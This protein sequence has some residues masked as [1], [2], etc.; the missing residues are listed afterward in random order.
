M[1]EQ[2]IRA[3]YQRMAAS[4]QPPSCV[5][6]PA[7]RRSG[8]ARLRWRW[9][10]IAGTPLLTAAAV[11]AIALTGAIPAGLL[12]KRGSTPPVSP[13]QRAPRYFNPL[14]P[15]VSFGW[16]PADASVR[17]TGIYGLTS[18]MV[19][20]PEPAPQTHI[21]LAVYTA[22]RC[23]VTRH[24]LGCSF[25]PGERVSSVPLGHR[26]GY[27]DGQPAYWLQTAAAAITTTT[28]TTTLPN[29]P[30]TLHWQYARGGW[31]TLVAP[32]LPQALRIARHVR[33]GSAAST[34]VRFP[35]QLTGVPT[36]WQINSVA[37]RWFDGVQYPSDFVVTAGPVYGMPVEVYPAHTP[38]FSVYPGKKNACAR[39]MQ[40]PTSAV[41]NGYR[42]TLATDKNWIWP[43]QDLCAGDVSGMSLWIGI[44]VWPTLSA[45]DLFGRHMRLLGSDPA[46]W[47]TQPIG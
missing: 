42:V 9:A 15:Y 40:H 18:E 37:T 28:S 23:A 8:R 45:A 34:P 4:D 44:G 17:P 41:I 32:S 22:G 25:A 31:A 19:T 12:G 35:F 3:V 2:E 46:N 30:P 36:D 38:S 13:P 29:L 10:G 24:A 39:L 11:L 20:E 26:V 5:S 27:V 6:L 21:A 14:L 43:K 47:T 1:L 33:F 7:A 16:L